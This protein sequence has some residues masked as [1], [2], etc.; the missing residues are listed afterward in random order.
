MRLYNLNSLPLYPN[1]GKRDNYSI[2]KKRGRKAWR[3]R[4]E[5]QD[6]TA[7]AVVDLGV[8][9]W[10]EHVFADGLLM[11]YLYL[12]TR[13]LFAPFKTHNVTLNDRHRILAQPAV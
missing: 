11:I 12:P 4:I 2:K 5:T 8:A 9:L 13:E 3:T 10:S 6:R 7:W 1:S